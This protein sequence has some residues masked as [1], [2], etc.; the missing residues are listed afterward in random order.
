MGLCF[1]SLQFL[2]FFFCTKIALNNTFQY[3]CTLE[4]TKFLI[5]IVLSKILRYADPRAFYYC[6]YSCCCCSLAGRSSRRTSWWDNSKCVVL[7]GMA[8][9]FI[10][11]QCFQKVSA[12]WVT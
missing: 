4:D 9:K 10:Q 2:H 7:N 11:I 5:I 3:T 1:Q 6:C 8:T 12:W